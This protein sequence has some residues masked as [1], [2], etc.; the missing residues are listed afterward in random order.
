MNTPVNSPRSGKIAA[1]NVS[2]GQSVQ[3]G[4]SLVSFE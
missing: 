1:V 2:A 4:Q 3:E